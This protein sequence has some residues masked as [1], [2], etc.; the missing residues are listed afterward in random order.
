MTDEIVDRA[1]YVIV[2]TQNGLEFA[3]GGTADMFR[4]GQVVSVEGTDMVVDELTEEIRP[5]R[6]RNGDVWPVWWL[7]KMVP[8]G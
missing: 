4:V 1:E 3:I 7:V 5:T 2:L 6:D 8:L